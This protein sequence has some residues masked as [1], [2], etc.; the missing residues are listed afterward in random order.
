MKKLGA[1]TRLRNMAVFSSSVNRLKDAAIVP[2]VEHTLLAWVRALPESKSGVLIGGLALSF[3]AKPRYTTDVDV[4]FLQGQVPAS[5]PGFKRHR[6]GAFQENQTQVEVEF[7]TASSVG[8]PETVVHKVIE[9]AHS[10]DGLKV[11]S[12]AGLVVLKLF[13]SR[14]TKRHFQDLADIQKLL[15]AHPSLDLAD[16]VEL[17]PDELYA[18]FLDLKEKSV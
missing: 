13:G 2:E 11:C 7:V 14:S 17:L 8:I 9:T 16:W 6:T 1:R 12:L 18:R 5:V 10:V 4:L 15:V 3:Y